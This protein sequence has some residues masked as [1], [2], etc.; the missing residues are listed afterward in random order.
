MV[1]NR[2]KLNIGEWVRTWKQWA[3]GN[4]NGKIYQLAVLLGLT[5]SPSFEMIYNYRT[6]R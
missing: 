6:R 5:R 4:T 1:Q 3:R 2:P